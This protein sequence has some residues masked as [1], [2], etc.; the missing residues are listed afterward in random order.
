MNPFGVDANRRRQ[1]ETSH[2]AD[3]A[4]SF[5]T[6]SATASS[7]RGD[8]LAGPSAL[9]LDDDEASSVIAASTVESVGSR[10]AVAP[11]WLAAG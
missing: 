5:V 6:R 2:F 8:R 4:A 7:T 10:P 11:V 1:E 9:R 3:L